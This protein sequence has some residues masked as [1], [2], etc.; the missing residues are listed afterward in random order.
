MVGP[1]NLGKTTL[2]I[3]VFGA[4]DFEPLKPFCCFFFFVRSSQLSMWCFCCWEGLVMELHSK[5]RQKKALKHGPLGAI[6]SHA[7]YTSPGLC[8][9]RSAL[10][11]SLDDHFPDPKWRAKGRNK[12]GVVNQLYKAARH[13]D[14]ENTANCDSDSTISKERGTWKRWKQYSIYGFTWVPKAVE[15]KITYGSHQR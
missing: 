12:M 14:N 9:S 4:W 10:M 1:K 5:K 15:T 13:E 7:R 6:C 3:Y 11:S 8:L 2:K